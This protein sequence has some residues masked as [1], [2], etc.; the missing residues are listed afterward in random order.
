M[1]KTN[2]RP[3]AWNAASRSG[4]PIDVRHPRHAGDGKPEVPEQQAQR[5][6]PAQALRL[7]GSAGDVETQQPDGQAD[8]RQAIEHAAPRGRHG[9][10]S[11]ADKLGA[12]DDVERL[13]RPFA[14][15]HEARHLQPFRG[16]GQHE[17]REP[18][19]ED[20]R[21][22]GAGSEQQIADE[23][24]RCGDEQKHGVGGALPRHDQHVDRRRKR[25]PAVT[26][27]QRAASG[28]PV[29]MRSPARPDAIGAAKEK[30]LLTATARSIPMTVPM[31]PQIIRNACPTTAWP[32]QAP[33]SA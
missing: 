4:W 12:E 16:D 17:E 29:S 21:R 15:T 7:D 27:S 22:R 6:V 1:L 3:R 2:P 11:A 28:C 31:K 5:H 23:P 25:S 33:D 32:P 8:E 13:C 10:C 9:R 14:S 30:R 18:P 19:G 24:G 26:A 20:G